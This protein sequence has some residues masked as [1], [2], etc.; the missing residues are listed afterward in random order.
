M[1]GLGFENWK[2]DTEEEEQKAGGE[3]GLVNYPRKAGGK[4]GLGNY[5][6]HCNTTQ[7]IHRSTTASIDPNYRQSTLMSPKLPPIDTD[8]RGQADSKPHL[9]PSLPP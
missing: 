8:H 7:T 4:E 3:E 1:S 9:T 2:N 5:H 6:N